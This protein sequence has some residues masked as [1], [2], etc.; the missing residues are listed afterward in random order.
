[1]SEAYKMGVSY[2]KGSPNIQIG[3]PLKLTWKNRGGYGRKH[4]V[5]MEIILNKVRF[6]HETYPTTT[7]QASR[8]VLLIT[9]LEIRDRLAISNINK[10]LYHPTIGYLRK[11]GSQH[12]LVV[13]ALHLRPDPT[14]TT[15]ECCLRISLLPLRLNIDQDSLLF[16]INFF[17]SL[18]RSSS[19]IASS[20]NGQ[21]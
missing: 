2:S 19:G 18:A 15:Q 7:E 12:M 20:Q 17:S 14:Q 4:D 13:K 11:Q 16:L 5:L 21:R 9:E 10:F 3:N 1:M 6:S 8:Q